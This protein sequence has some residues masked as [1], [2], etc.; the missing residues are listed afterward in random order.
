MYR[1]FP[2]VPSVSASMCYRT[3]YPFVYNNGDMKKLGVAQYAFTI[4]KLEE[5][6]Y[7]LRSKSIKGEVV[8]KFKK[9]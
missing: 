5:I 6:S 3:K 8:E 7:R 1:T 2:S 4:T 9:I